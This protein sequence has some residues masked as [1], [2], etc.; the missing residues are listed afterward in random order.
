MKTAIQ[1][2]TRFC[3]DVTAIPIQVVSHTHFH[4]LIIVQFPWDSHSHFE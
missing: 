3:A 2:S 1:E 4:D